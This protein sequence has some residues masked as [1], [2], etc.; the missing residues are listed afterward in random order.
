MNLTGLDL[1]G[2]VVGGP[3]AMKDLGGQ[4][5]RFKWM[6]EGNC[7]PDTSSSENAFHKNGEIITFFESNF[8]VQAERVKISCEVASYCDCSLP[9]YQVLSPP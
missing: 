3:G 9:T 4:Q 7:S 2:S 1:G 8:I 5:S 6:M